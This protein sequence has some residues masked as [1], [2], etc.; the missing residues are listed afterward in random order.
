MVFAILLR[1]PVSLPYGSVKYQNSRYV[2]QKTC[3]LP[4]PDHPSEK[5]FKKFDKRACKFGQN[6]LEYSSL[7]MLM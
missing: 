2:L 4:T 1:K 3:E 5:N 7:P 6:M